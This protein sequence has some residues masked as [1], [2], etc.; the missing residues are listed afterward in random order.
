MRNRIRLDTAKDV[1]EFVNIAG[2]VT[3]DVMITD[4]KFT[5]NGK[6]LLGVMYCKAEF[7]NLWVECSEDIYHKIEKF[8]I[9]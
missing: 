4:D 9:E 6:S 2:T 1:E 3:S 7:D 5:V 8:I